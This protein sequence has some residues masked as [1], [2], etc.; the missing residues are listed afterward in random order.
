MM[1]WLWR[2]GTADVTGDGWRQD[3]NRVAL[4]IAVL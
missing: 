3:D 2:Y 4:G 1:Q